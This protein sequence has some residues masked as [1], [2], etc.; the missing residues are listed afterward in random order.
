[1]DPSTAI[2]RQPT[3][4]LYREERLADR[5]GGGR[6]RALRTRAPLGATA[7]HSASAVAITTHRGDRERAH[8]RSSCRS[9]CILMSKADSSAISSR[10]ISD[11]A[12]RSRPG[13][14]LRP[15]LG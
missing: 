15:K 9:A 6:K 10:P 3:V 4:R 5:K 13:L 7:D 2:R 1:M 14:E 8:P 12:M 11:C